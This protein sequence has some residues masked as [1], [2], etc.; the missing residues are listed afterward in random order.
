MG[1][2]ARLERDLATEEQQD[3]Q[4]RPAPPAPEVPNREMAQLLPQLTDPAQLAALRQSGDPALLALL[5]QAA[6]AQAA[7]AQQATPDPATLAERIV[8]AIGIWET[9]R[10]GDAP[11]P[12][13]ST[14]DTV[15]G[16]K[17]SMKSAVQAT[18]IFAVDLINRFPSLRERADPPLTKTELKKAIDRCH[19][20]DA[21]HAAVGKAVA[22]GTDVA[23]FLVAE[24]TL[25]EQA[26]LTEAH[27]HTMFAAAELK[28]EINEIR[29]EYL[30]ADKKG[31][32]KIRAELTAASELGI[33]DKSLKAYIETP[34]KWGEHKAAWHRV[35]V[36]A[37]P[38][39]V[40]PRIESVALADEG[41]ALALPEYTRLV[42]AAVAADPKATEEDIV[43]SVAQRN[44]SR[45]PA[46]G[47]HVWEI[48]KKLYVGAV[49][50]KTPT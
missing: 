4:R 20:V 34:T 25:V 44:N 40:G 27:V 42:K 1:G 5:G 37:M 15:A 43:T 32:A 46:Y 39:D 17:A 6:G 30:K 16:V 9:N 49:S 45:E 41:T 8:F 23:E 48:Y 19:G 12:K 7:T 33:D 2:N 28:N 22:K 26:G 11:A 38:D 35:A 31:K 10:G 21:L 13:E 24:G 50:P 18:M 36:N 29:P 3:P 47:S 14:L